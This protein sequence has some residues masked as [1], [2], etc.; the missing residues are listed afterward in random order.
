M[1][2]IP[3][4][5]SRSS[6]ECHS[7]ADRSPVVIIKHAGKKYNLELDPTSNGETFK[8]QIYSVTGVEPDRQKVLVKGG[9]LKDD[10]DMSKLGIK[11]N[12]AIMVMGSAGRAPAA[13]AKPKDAPKFLED[14]TEAEVAQSEGAMPAGLQNL[15]N[16]CYMNSTLQTLRAIPELQQELQTYTVGASRSNGP[17]LSQFGLQGLGSSSD[18][19]GS[20]RDLY[21][22]MGQ[23]QD[24]FP[25]LMFLNAFRAK[26]PQFAEKARDGHGYAQQ[27]A[28][29]AWSQLVS[30]LQHDLPV[31]ATPAAPSAD[32]SASTR[33]S[34]ID[35]YLGGIFH[36]VET[37]TD[38]ALA[39][40]EP[41]KDKAPQP[42]YK[43]NCH[44]AS[45]EIKHL[46][47]GI[48][49]ALRDTYTK[50]SPTR[51]A[52]AEYA[53]DSRI[54]RLPKYL[55]VH[56]V[57]FF[58][59][60]DVNKKAKILRKVTFPHELDCVE[61][62]TDA[63]RAQLL[64]V[65]DAVRDLRKEL[66]D[67][68]RARKR[69]KRARDDAAAAPAP[70]GGDTSMVAADEGKTDA[71]LD[72]ERA[73]TIAR[74]KVALHAALPRATDAGA[75]TTGLYELR[76]VIT[77][78]GASADSGHYTAYVKKDG[79]VG[80][81]KDDAAGAGDTWWWF[82]DDKVTEVEG[83]RVAA[84]SGG[85]ESASALILLYRAVEVP[86]VSE[87]ERRLAEEA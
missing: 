87:A 53:T 82:N 51:N 62:C 44:V 4:T 23:T 38:P 50:T 37:P 80:A 75:N 21:K 64:P 1:S 76:G 85:G 68:A 54:A 10:Q 46:R 72:H 86:A 9:Q 22:Q 13:I 63:L 66:E 57:R 8:Y 77:H 83:E 17:D 67:D 59:K 19:T 52:E 33:K 60:R 26:Y 31:S 18:L 7:E 81:G 15:G 71:Q 30:T 74:A 55:P 61:Y 12:A 65:R 20:L 34:F 11:P 58:W 42:F 3:G 56:F 2:S 27:D 32:A 69:Q 43:L 45:Q 35:T 28:E 49:S 39:E 36:S 14:M 5:W 6:L 40:A 25:P 16:T 48:H 70:S 24:G 73:V 29:E 41:A 47:E 78:A 79:A 84:L